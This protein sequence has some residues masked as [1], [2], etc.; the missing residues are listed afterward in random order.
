ML[1]NLDTLTKKRGASQLVSWSDNA[2]NRTVGN[3]LFKTTGSAYV[4]I[5]RVPVWVPHGFSKIEW[6]LQGY[7]TAGSGGQ[8]KLVSNADP[9]GVE[10]AAFVVGGW[11]AGAQNTAEWQDNNAG[12]AGLLELDAIGNAWDTIT[13]SIKGGGSGT[14]YLTA[15]SIWI[16]EAT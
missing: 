15:L 10:S 6:S 9:T 14:T 3:F 7:T 12:G 8:I 4:P 1:A 2:D 13:V 5:L 11:T 16:K